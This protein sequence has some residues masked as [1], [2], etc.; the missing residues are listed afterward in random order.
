MMKPLPPGA[1]VEN[2]KDIGLKCII[3]NLTIGRKMKIMRRKMN[4]NL[5]VGCEDPE[6]MSSLLAA[7]ASVEQIAIVRN[8]G[9]IVWQPAAIGYMANC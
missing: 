5:Y 2:V 7:Y 9:A 1:I 8:N 6:L 3:M 4:E